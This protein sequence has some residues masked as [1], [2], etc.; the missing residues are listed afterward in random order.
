MPQVFGKYAGTVEQNFDPFGKG[1]LLVK[2]PAVFGNGTV[3]ATP[4]VP[5]AGPNVGFFAMP[6]KDTPVWVEF[7]AGD[8]N[9][10]IWSG[11]FWKDD[12][13]APVSVSPVAEKKKVLK[14]ESCTLTLDDTPGLG[15]IT[16][17]FGILKIEIKSQGI[18]ITDG[19]GASIKLTGPQVSINGNALEVT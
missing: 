16:I 11:C 10:P 2:V 14:T 4:C 1:R 9:C 18:E 6:P 12:R 3:W 17:E 15:G 7:E 13:S 8:P 19:Q 5:Y